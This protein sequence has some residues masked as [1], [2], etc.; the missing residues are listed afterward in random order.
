MNT[1]PFRQFR[2]YCFAEIRLSDSNILLEIQA[3]WLDQN[4]DGV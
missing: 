4:L 1:V 3:K 2:E